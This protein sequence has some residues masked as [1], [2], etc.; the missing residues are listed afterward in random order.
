[1]VSEELKK[2][3]A[4]EIAKRIKD[5]ETIG[6][7]SGSTVWIAIHAIGKRIKTE[8]ITVR[9]ICASGYTEN[10]A[11]LNNIEVL[12]LLSETQAIWGFDGADEIDANLN[13]LKGGWGAHT[14]EKIIANRCE[15]FIIIADET[16][17][18]QN[19]GNSRL[20]PIE[21]IPE[22]KIIV[23]RQL[24]LLGA[25]NATLRI[26]SRTRT[27]FLTEFTNN[28]IIDAKFNRPLTQELCDKINS[29]CGVVENGIFINYADEALI[30]TQSGVRT[31]RKTK[32]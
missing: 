11:E 29:I 23:E 19:L 32:Y 5:G 28:Y 6:I 15:K 8:Q 12:P 25:T 30:A 3:V 21:I 4:I 7:G 9:A 26:D 16:K 22:S 20:L 31:M 2:S 13:L 27:A 1:M 14:R 18:V 17:L 10:L 24:R